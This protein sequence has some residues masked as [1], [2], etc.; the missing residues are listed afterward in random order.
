MDVE[1]N[2]DGQSTPYIYTRAHTRILSIG[3]VKMIEQIHTKGWNPTIPQWKNEPLSVPVRGCNPTTTLCKGDPNS[4]G[5]T[6]QEQQQQQ[7]Q[8]GH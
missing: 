8:H 3:V 7:Q 2:S 6:Q 5:N 1:T 4:R